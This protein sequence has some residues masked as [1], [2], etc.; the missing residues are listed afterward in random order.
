MNMQM[1]AVDGDAE[2]S[3]REQ[4][5]W[6]QYG[7]YTT[8][9]G[10]MQ[11][12][13]EELSRK[14]F[15]FTA[16]NADN[17]NYLPMLKIMRE[18]APSPIFIITSDFKIKEHTEVLL[19]GADVYAHFQENVEEHILLALAALQRY[20]ERDRPPN[21][22][23]NRPPIIIMTYE[24]LFVFPAFRQVF[25]NDVEIQLTKME[26]DI[27]CYLIDN[28]GYALTF[29]Q[30]YREIWGLGYDDT[31]HNVLWSHMLNLRKKIALAAGNGYIDNV[32]DVGYRLPIRNKKA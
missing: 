31:A 4:A 1:L 28:R 21:R 13:I 18:A 5:I 26:F 15:L 20:N 19:N 2:V 7:I 30:I 25:C 32:R 9:A 16:I 22:P 24:K 29:T 27:L 10:S 6:R 14:P 8:R 23:P 17:I 11:G 12:A 3:L